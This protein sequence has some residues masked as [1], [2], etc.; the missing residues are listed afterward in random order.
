M[1]LGCNNH[2]AH[3]LCHDGIELYVVNDLGV[4][5]HEGQCQVG[6]GQSAEGGG[7][8]HEW[9]ARSQPVVTLG[10]RAGIGEEKN[11]PQKAAL[12]HYPKK[13]FAVSQMW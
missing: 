7:G 9:K 13:K 11:I 3:D 8:G 10:E 6:G 12:R 5:G 1:V 4:V 2:V